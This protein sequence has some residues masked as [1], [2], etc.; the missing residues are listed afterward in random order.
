MAWPDLFRISHNRKPYPCEPV[1]NQVIFL[2]RCIHQPQINY[3]P[4][5]LTSTHHS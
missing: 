1:G 4:Q 3:E 2:P 5:H